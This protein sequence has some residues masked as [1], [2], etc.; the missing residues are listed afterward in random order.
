MKPNYALR[1]IIS[2]YKLRIDQNSLSSSSISPDKQN[3]EKLIKINVVSLPKQIS[4][5]I[6]KELPV[7]SL[8]EGSQVLVEAFF[9]DPWIEY[10]LPDL[11][12]RR[13]AL[14]FFM[15]IVVGIYII[16]TNK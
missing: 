2:L 3:E 16:Y 1:D 5:Y 15:R 10:F 4:E 6:L 9:N 7:K 14:H 13:E 11:K 8:D 12:S